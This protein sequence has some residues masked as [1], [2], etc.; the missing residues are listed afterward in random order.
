M[1]VTFYRNNSEDNAINK[2]LTP[3]V[4]LNNV[5]AKGNVDVVNPTLIVEFDS[6]YTDRINYA[7]IDDYDSYYF[8]AKPIAIT[9]SRCA[10]QLKRDALETFKSDI[11][12]LTAIVD[13]TEEVSKSNMY[14]NDGSFVVQ[15]NEY[16]RVMNFP[17]GFNENG[18]FILICAGGD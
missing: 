18:T 5:I 14:L 12:E 6:D 15:S 1:K 17:S 11:L 7:K 13:K 16:N 2:S 4:T 9:G 10:V 8:L 3:I